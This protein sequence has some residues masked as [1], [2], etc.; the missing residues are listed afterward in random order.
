MTGKNGYR[1]SHKHY[2][3]CVCGMTGAMWSEDHSLA[4]LVREA[5]AEHAIQ[6]P[7]ADPDILRVEN[8]Q[9]RKQRLNIGRIVNDPG[10]F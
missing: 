10:F 9:Q 3:K 7:C 6:D 8:E 2:W 4:G 1:E 5:R